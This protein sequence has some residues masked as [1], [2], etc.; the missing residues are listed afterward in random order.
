MA[1]AGGVQCLW[2]LGRARSGTVW[3]DRVGCAAGVV[4]M[5]GSSASRGYASSSLC[6]MDGKTDSDG[7]G[8]GKS[9]RALMRAEKV[10]KSAAKLKSESGK[11]N[12]GVEEGDVLF[13]EHGSSRHIVLNRPSC[14][15][16][17]SAAMV[18]KIIPM[19]DYWEADSSV[20]SI[21]VYGSG[22]KAFCAGGDVVE[23]REAVQRKDANL[24]PSL[25]NE[26]MLYYNLSKLKKP[27]IALMDGYTMGSGVGL[28]VHGSYN[29]ATAKTVWAMPETAIGFFPD[30]GCGYF[31]P[32]LEGKLGR[33]LGLTG[34]RV[35]G[36]DA[37]YTGIATHYLDESAVVNLPHVLSVLPPIQPGTLH[38]VDI[39]TVYHGMVKAVLD[40]LM[41]ISK[42]PSISPTFSPHVIGAIDTCFGDDS[43]EGI[44]EKLHQIE[45][46]EQ[47]HDSEFLC[48]WAGEQIA[49]LGTKSPLSLKVTLEQ[50]NI[51]SK[52]SLKKVLEMEYNM[53][54]NMFRYQDFVEGVRALLVD[55]D[56]TPRWEFPMLSSIDS[57]IVK[58]I[59]HTPCTHE[60]FVL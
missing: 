49:M 56:E 19:I 3:R 60:P 30:V 55:K 25:A 40:Q 44:I 2:G 45:N 39:N 15:N 48:E 58:D 23:L 9:T 7:A 31:L 24:M 53:S 29:I 37:L 16:A 11:R 6:F 46:N 57:K 42:T 5:R 38:G 59:V 52:M 12:Q 47:G 35:K 4:L 26:Y 50:L 27:Y 28:S 20:S 21:V 22:D 1:L 43:V 51:G 14:L 33:Y 8:R 41:T 17:L 54:H 34:A 32:R 36:S 13:E 10:R 18:S